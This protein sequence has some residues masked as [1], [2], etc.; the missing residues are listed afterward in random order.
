MDKTKLSCVITTSE[1]ASK[2]KIPAVIHE[3]PQLLFIKIINES[4]IHLKQ[5]F[6][7]TIDSCNA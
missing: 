7:N 2:I 6:S 3:N 4:Y 5:M 1:I